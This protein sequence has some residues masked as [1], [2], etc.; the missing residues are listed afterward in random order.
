MASLSPDDRVELLAS[1]LPY[2]NADEA[3]AWLSVQL[4]E[5]ASSAPAAALVAQHWHRIGP[6]DRPELTE[7]ARRATA[8]LQ[9]TVEAWT[10]VE[11]AGLVQLATEVH[12]LRAPS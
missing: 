11:R 3:A 7:L 12:Q 4:I 1:A 9:I 6:A 2:A 8:D 10:E 5:D